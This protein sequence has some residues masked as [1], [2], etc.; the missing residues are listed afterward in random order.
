MRMI[1]CDKKEYYLEYTDE[2]GVKQTIFKFKG[3]EKGYVREYQMKR[4]QEPSITIR[5]PENATPNMITEFY[6]TFCL[7]KLNTNITM[8]RIRTRQY[9]NIG[10]LRFYQGYKYFK[11]TYSGSDSDD[12]ILPQ[13]GEQQ[14]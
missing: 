5:L 9:R 8:M 6:K 14:A 3:L 10:G 1:L 11:K 13:E 4:G 2:K 12:D 7:N